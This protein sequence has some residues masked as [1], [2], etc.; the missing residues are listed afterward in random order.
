M[1]LLV[2]GA[3]RW[4][5]FGGKDVAFEENPSPSMQLHV[6]PLYQAGKKIGDVCNFRLSFTTS[7]E[8]WS[9]LW[10]EAAQKGIFP[11]LRFH[12]RPSL[13]GPVDQQGERPIFETCDIS[14]ETPNEKLPSPAR[15]WEPRRF[16]LPRGQACWRVNKMAEPGTRLATLICGVLTS[17]TW[18]ERLPRSAD[19]SREGLRI[20]GLWR[21]EPI[22]TS[23]GAEAFTRRTCS[24]W[25]QQAFR[26]WGREQGYPGASLANE[27]Y[28]M[29]E[30]ISNLRLWGTTQSR[31][32]DMG[33][34]IV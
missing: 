8:W 29:K 31:S 34:R 28:S 1:L 33:W 3:V 6:R 9:S 20:S 4:R 30:F 24:H 2:A 7:L 23:Q 22:L 12:Y 16:E 18:V 15:R 26:L 19:G 32:F 17:G 10:S 5:R 14:V 27:K 13:Y 11:G 21:G 25:F